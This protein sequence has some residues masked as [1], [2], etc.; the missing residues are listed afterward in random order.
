M[1]LT[2]DKKFIISTHYFF[3]IPQKN[4]FYCIKDFKTCYADYEIY[5]N[6]RGQFE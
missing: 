2:C 4:M 6:I 3:N 5:F 1:K